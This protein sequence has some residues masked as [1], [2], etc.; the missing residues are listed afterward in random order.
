MTRTKK[1]KPSPVLEQRFKKAEKTPTQAM[2]AE[3][4]SEEG[5]ALAL[6]LSN[7]FFVRTGTFPRCT[8]KKTYQAWLS[9]ALAT[10][11]N[12]IFCEDCTVNYE[13]HMRIAG[14]CDKERMI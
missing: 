12:P 3:K 10:S 9:S 1:H 8:D 6:G 7:E 11:R 2:D 13:Q 4:Q 14:R 5:K